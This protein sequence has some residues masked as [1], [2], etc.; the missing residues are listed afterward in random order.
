MKMLAMALAAFL[1]IGLAATEEKVP[2]GLANVG[3][4][5]TKSEAGPATAAG[6]QSISA[7]VMVS[8][9]LI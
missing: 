7:S 2:N 6:E 1:L 9:E 8:F 5:P 4:A 3:Y